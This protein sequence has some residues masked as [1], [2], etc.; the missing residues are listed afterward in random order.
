[1]NFDFLRKT[2]SNRERIL[3]TRIFNAQ[4][5][6]KLLL[7]VESNPENRCANAKKRLQT[8]AGGKLNTIIQKTFGVV[9][10]I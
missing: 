2:Y 3:Q 7:E 9:N 1:M 6:L 5:F 4:A 8:F 10:Y